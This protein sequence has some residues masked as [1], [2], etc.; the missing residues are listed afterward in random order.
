MIVE[1]IHS[2]ENFLSRLGDEPKSLRTQYH[3]EKE[4]QVRKNQKVIKNDDDELIVKNYPK[5]NNKLSNN[6]QNL[7]HQIVLVVREVIG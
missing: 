5:R 7:N 1:K 3:V 6:N 2:T 4:T